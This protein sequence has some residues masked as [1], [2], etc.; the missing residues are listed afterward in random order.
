MTR[1]KTSYRDFKQIVSDNNWDVKQFVQKDRSVLV[2][3]GSEQEWFYIETDDGF[4][5]L[6]GQF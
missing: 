6:Q 2:D 5:R 4:V 3:K 1:N